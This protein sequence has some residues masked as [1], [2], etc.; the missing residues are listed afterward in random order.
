[1]AVNATM[2]AAYGNANKTIYE[3]EAVQSTIKEVTTKQAEAFADMKKNLTFD[4]EQIINYLK[5]N[6]IKDY[7]EGK[8]AIQLNF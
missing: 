3:A 2:M 1:M 8:M 6:L 4:N 5:I 7:P